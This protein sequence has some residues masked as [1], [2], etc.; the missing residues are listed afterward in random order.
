[1]KIHIEADSQEEFD[2]K[3]FDLVKALVGNPPIAPRDGYY[4]FQN[5]MMEYFNNIF[6]FRMSRIKGEIAEIFANKLSE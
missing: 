4:Q 1:M 3:K 6:K 5:E 2:E